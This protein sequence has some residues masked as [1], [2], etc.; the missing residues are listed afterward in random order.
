MRNF[1][2]SVRENQS[3]WHDD[4]ILVIL[5]KS[6]VIFFSVFAKIVKNDRLNKDIKI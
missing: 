3:S 6:A 1:F 4:F 2:D 5:G